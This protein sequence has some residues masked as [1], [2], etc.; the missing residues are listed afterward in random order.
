MT[1]KLTPPMM[2]AMRR[3][4]G[5]MSVGSCRRVSPC[6]VS[7]TCSGMSAH[8][9]QSRIVD[10]HQRRSPKLRDEPPDPDAADCCDGGEVQPMGDGKVRRQMAPLVVVW[11]DDPEEI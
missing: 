10:W 5:S 2:A 6:E 4:G 11:H 7:M 9:R 8:L 3:G 1:I